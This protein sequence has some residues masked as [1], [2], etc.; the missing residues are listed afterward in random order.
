MNIKKAK[1]LLET[2]LDELKMRKTFSHFLSEGIGDNDD[3][4]NTHYDMVSTI[5]DRFYEF[6]SSV[7]FDLKDEDYHEN[8]VDL[9]DS[10][11]YEM[12]LE[13]ELLRMRG[14]EDEHNKILSQFER[15]TTHLEDWKTWQS[16]I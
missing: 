15:N 12:H 9:V 6:F 11:L 5:A 14:Y 4:L 1:A 2:I 13:E 16:G 7:P 10:I 8:A 3:R